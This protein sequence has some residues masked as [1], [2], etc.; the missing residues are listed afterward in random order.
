M[1]RKQ[2][3]PPCPHCGGMD[4]HKHGKA[5]SGRKRY[6]CC[7]CGQTF[8]LRTKTTIY[9][10][11]LKDREWK[12][13]INLHCLRGGVSGRDIARFL[14]K[15]HKTGQRIN[16]LLRER[17][18]LMPI[19]TLVREVEVDETTTS[20]KW[21]IGM[22]SRQQK[23]LVLQLIPNRTESTLLP[24]VRKHTHKYALVISDEWSGYRNLSITRNHLTVCHQREFVSRYH[25]DIHTNTVEGAWGLI[26]PLI[27]QIY[28]GLPKETIKEYLPEFMFRYNVRDYKT[29]CQVLQSYLNHKSHT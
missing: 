2:N 5:K 20:S 21:I 17:Q 11:K 9:R 19:K 14:G 27:R 1:T 28:R 18:S 25:P 23:K 4:V 29:R 24:T 12:Q 6:K 10:S 16:R 8:C 15:N 22:L 26:K 13:A 3:A 7:Y